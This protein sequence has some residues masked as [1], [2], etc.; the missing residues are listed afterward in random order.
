MLAALFTGVAA[1]PAAAQ[2][3]ALAELAQLQADLQA[4]DYRRALVSA[5][6]IAG[7]HP[8]VAHGSALYAWLLHVGGQARFAQRVLAQALDRRPGD[9]LLQAVREQLRSP[10]PRTTAPWRELGLAPRTTGIDPDGGA[11]A[12]GSALLAPAGDSAFAP[13][14]LLDGASAL[15][16]R[17]GLGRTVRA[18][19]KQAAD[20]GV[21]ELAL[22]PALPK[23]PGYETALH[24]PFAG[25]PGV[26]VEHAAAP[27]AAPAWPLLRAGF[28]GRGGQLGLETPPG[29]RGGPAFDLAGRVVGIALPGAG[30]P[31]RLLPC[32][33]FLPPGSAGETAL[34]PARLAQD[35]L[36]EFALRVALQ[37][38]VPA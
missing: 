18:T 34:R 35:A 6:H 10:W 16:L 7:G 14:A 4:G 15:W 26:T 5:S 17:D 36:Y 1:R 32:A 3:L 8:E 30:G 23:V 20:S 38:V 12:V 27:D 24:P 21:A 29:P 31:D 25:S 22:S 37:V 28:F 9:P 11:R 2:H 19:P 13:A 33:R